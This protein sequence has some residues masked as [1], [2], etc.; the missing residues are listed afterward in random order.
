MTDWLKSWGL[1]DDRLQDDWKNQL[2]GFFT[3]RASYR[4][5]P[6]V[7]PGDRLFYYAVG[8]RVVFG[9]YDVTSLPFQ[10]DEDG[11][12]EWQVKV[13]PVVD[14]DALHDGVPLENLNVGARPHDLLMSVRQKAAIRL[15]QP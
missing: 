13:K 9:L 10:S 5:R 8:H 4:R 14:L 7:R 2:N 12:F 15:H 3:R 1:P 6:S 11:E